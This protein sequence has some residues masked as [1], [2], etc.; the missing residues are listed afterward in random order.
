MSCLFYMAFIP[1]Y[2]FILMATITV[3]YFAGL[4]IEDAA[5]RKR[6]AYLAMSVV[7]NIGM[8]ALFKYFDFFI[9]NFDRLARFASLPVSMPLLHIMLPLGLSFHTF[10]ALSYTIEVYYGGQKAERH[11]GI[12]ALYVMFFPQLVAGPIERPQHMLHQFR[13]QKFLVPDNVVAGLRLMLW[14]F[15][16]KLV[17]ADRLAMY[18]DPVFANYM[19][20]SGLNLALAA[21]FFVFQIYCDFSGYSDIALGAARVMG[22]KLM[23]N[24]DRPLRSG[25]ITEFW[26]R[27]H[28]SLST[29]LRDYVY[30]PLTVKWRYGG[31]AAV[32]AALMVTFLASGVWHGAGW[33]FVMLGLV[34]GVAVCYETLTRKQRRQWSR[35][36]PSWFYVTASIVLTLAAVSFIQIFFRA[37][38]A[39]HAFAYIHRIVSADGVYQW[40]VGA[41]ARAFGPYSWTVAGLGMMGMIAVEERTKPLLEEFRNSYWGNVAF[42]ATVL[43]AV[44][45]FGVFDQTSFIYFQF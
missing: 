19:Q 39:A 43:C 33:N 30:T 34:Y 16:K 11:P 38:N 29:W 14:G 18:V 44:L 4:L 42:C 26:R 13:E 40:I 24:F 10:Q 3:D 1:A 23:I 37:N 9:E 7:A 5:G 45:V 20:Y 32:L 12:Y 21:V 15:F 31:M 6:K 28:I 25:N 36:L 2:I 27:W 17:I 41:D 8:L 35:R 22:Y